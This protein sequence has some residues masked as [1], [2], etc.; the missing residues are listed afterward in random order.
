MLYDVLA[1]SLSIFG[2]GTLLD[3][4]FVKFRNPLW[5][6][7]TT[8]WGSISQIEVREFQR[9]LARFLL[10]YAEKIEEKDEAFRGFFVALLSCIWSAFVAAFSIWMLELGDDESAPVPEILEGSLIAG[11]FAL[12]TLL[13]V[14]TLSILAK[15]WPFKQA[16]D[17][18]K[19]STANALVI[20]L[21]SPIVIAIALALTL[22]AFLAFLNIATAGSWPSAVSDWIPSIFEWIKI[23][24]VWVTAVW[25]IFFNAVFDVY[26]FR[27]TTVLLRWVA[28]GGVTRGF[29][30]PILDVG[31]ATAFAAISAFSVSFGFLI[32]SGITNV[33]SIGVYSVNMAVSALIPTILIA[34]SLIVMLFL[35]ISFKTIAHFS[36]LLFI[37]SK[38][39]ADA[40]TPK[41]FSMIALATLLPIW[42]IKMVGIFTKIPNSP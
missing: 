8:L 40:G 21:A 39:H 31:S 6:I 38:E 36:N 34:I 12:Y 23:K 24:R 17:S 27:V 41:P 9:D 13:V 42:L 11:A 37:I 25:V 30:G 3:F 5:R 32:M 26:S 2:L 22:G 33:T 10:K 14:P 18:M 15:T 35:F 29:F 4:I 28:R 16:F 19:Q 7:L 1:L 20:A